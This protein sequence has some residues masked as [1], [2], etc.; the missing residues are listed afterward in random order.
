MKLVNSLVL[1]KDFLLVIKKYLSNVVEINE[2]FCVKNKLN[3][4][5]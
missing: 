2:N 3:S 4:I 5:R 1:N